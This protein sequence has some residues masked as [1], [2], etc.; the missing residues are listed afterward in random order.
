MVC[1]FATLLSLALVLRAD[2]VGRIG[3][4][5]CAAAVGLTVYP[6]AVGGGLAEVPA[7]SFAMELFWPSLGEARVSASSC[8][9]V[10]YQDGLA[11]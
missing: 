5:L 9:P 11:S 2:G 6:V 3:L 10:P 4:T 7:L 8:S 1:T